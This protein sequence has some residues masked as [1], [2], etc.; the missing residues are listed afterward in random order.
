[1]YQSRGT[2]LGLTRKYVSKVCDSGSD[3]MGCW[4]WITIKGK[5]GWKIALLSAYRVFE[6]AL[7]QAEPQTCWLQ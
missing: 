4:S 3:Q 5:K 7:S 6:N 2:A 1:M